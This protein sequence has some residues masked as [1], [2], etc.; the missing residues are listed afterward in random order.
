MRVRPGSNTGF[1]ARYELA[2]TRAIDERGP[3]TMEQLVNYVEVA[4]CLILAIAFLVKR[5]EQPASAQRRFLVASLALLAYAG[6]NVVEIALKI[7]FWERWWLLVWILAS[8]AA[9][10][11]AFI[12]HRREQRGG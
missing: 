4:F 2:G 5:G 7:R 11:W 6:A 10:G 8:V 9:L 12:T 1:A 3:A